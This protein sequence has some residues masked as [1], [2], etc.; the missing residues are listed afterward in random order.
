[1][2]F[3]LN[4]RTDAYLLAGDRNPAEV[5]ADAIER[6]RAFLDAGADCVFVAGQLEAEVVRRLVEGIG[7]RKIS[8]LALP[9]TPEP[10]E[11]AELGVGRV[12]FGPWAQRVAMTA[13]AD[14]GTDLLA[15]AGLPDWA[16]NVS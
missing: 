12:S 15:G 3:V 6:G 1:V 9:G 7:E 2:P 8:V 11:L 4:A 13:L 10:R 16:R 5:L 14:V